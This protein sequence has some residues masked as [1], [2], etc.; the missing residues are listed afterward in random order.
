MIFQNPTRGVVVGGVQT[1]PPALPSDVLAGLLDHSNSTAGRLALALVAVHALPGHDVRHLLTA[2]L[3]LAKGRLVVRR[4]LRRHT[5]HLE[6]FTQG[7]SMEWL[8]ER[9]R[10]WPGS[11]NPYLLVSQQSAMHAEHPPVTTTMFKKTFRELNASLSQLRQDRILHEARKSADPLRLMR[12][13]GISD[14][15]AMRYISAAHPEKTSRL[16]R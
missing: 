1:L 5:I 9:H 11:T 7:I 8:S 16:P 4:G 6:E 10:R 13:F 12:L 15:T 2:D 14:T 3:D